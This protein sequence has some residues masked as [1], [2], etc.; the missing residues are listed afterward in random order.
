MP[1]GGARWFKHLHPTQITAINKIFKGSLPTFVTTIEFYRG[2]PSFPPVAFFTLFLFFVFYF[3]FL[4]ISML[5]ST[6]YHVRLLVSHSVKVSITQSHISC[7]P[8]SLT[9]LLVPFLINVL[10]TYPTL[11]PTS[12]S[13]TL[14]INLW[15]TY[16]PLLLT[17]RLIAVLISQWTIS[18]HLSS[19]L[20]LAP[21]LIKMFPTSLP[22][23][24]NYISMIFRAPS[25]T[26]LP[27]SKH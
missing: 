14:S 7:R 26:S 25:I 2:T 11:S 27:L 19:Q 8:H 20:L 16:L 5:L 18:H 3:Y 13:D 12:L 9:F 6:T 4:Q 21:I 22:L 17:S 24:K 10:T 23:C 1:P 15:I